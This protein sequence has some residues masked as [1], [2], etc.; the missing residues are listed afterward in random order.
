MTINAQKITAVKMAKF[1]NLQYFNN[2]NGLGS[3]IVVFMI[4][5][6][7]SLINFIS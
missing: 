2:I 1:Y 5:E 6:K 7:N 3:Y 4:L